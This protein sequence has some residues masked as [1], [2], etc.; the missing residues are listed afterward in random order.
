MMDIRNEMGNLLVLWLEALI[1]N[2]AMEDRQKERIKIVY[3]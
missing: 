1:L 2:P 3:S